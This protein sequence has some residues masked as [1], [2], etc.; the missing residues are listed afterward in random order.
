MKEMELEV[1]V[2]QIQYCVVMVYQDYVGWVC[3]LYKR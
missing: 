2:V 1:E 3:S